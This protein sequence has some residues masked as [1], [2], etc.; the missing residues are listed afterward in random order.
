MSKGTSIVEV[1]GAFT[2]KVPELTNLGAVVVQFPSLM[3]LSSPSSNVPAL[4]STLASPRLRSARD[5]VTP[6]SR[7]PWLNRVAPSS[8]CGPLPVTMA[9][10][11]DGTVA[12]KAPFMEP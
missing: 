4:S 8:S 3:A 6:S 11:P 1:L 12:V 5:D 9:V 7:V 2:V 10:A